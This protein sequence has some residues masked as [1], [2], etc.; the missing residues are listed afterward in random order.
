MFQINSFFNFKKS[1]QKQYVGCVRNPRKPNE[2]HKLLA[3]ACAHYGLTMIYYTP[4][5]VDMEQHQVT[6]KVLVNDKWITEVTDIPVFNDL[7][8]L[9]FRHK[10]VTNY[11]RQ[12]ST[13]SNDLI[14][15]KTKQ[16]RLVKDGEK[17][18]DIVIPYITTNQPESI[19]NFLSNHPM[20]ILKPSKGMRGEHIYKVSLLDDGRYHLI[21]ETDEEMLT[22]D[23]IFQFLYGLVSKKKYICQKY[24]ETVDEN[25][26]PFDVRIRLEKNVY[27]KWETVVNLVRIAGKQKIVSNVAQG[28]YVAELSS[29]LQVNYP[30]NWNAIEKKIIQI[31]NGL[32]GHIEELT[33]KHLSSLGIDIGIDPNGNTYLFEIN[34]SPGTEF[35]IGE[36][37]LIK[38]GYYYHKMNEINNANKKTQS[39]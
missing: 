9:C 15:A 37:A 34:T 30:D 14:G 6:G 20:V 4:K 38:S 18:K 35:A 24:I 17:F 31:G 25:D 39:M 8:T 10:D 33:G 11:L 26:K 3:K 2:F 12:I 23:E 29:F 22:Y 27:G 7:A 32:P 19:M 21:Y 36:I 1:K 13:I 28:G 5:D 16:Y